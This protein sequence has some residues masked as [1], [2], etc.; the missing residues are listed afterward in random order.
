M[1]R[2]KHHGDLEALEGLV[3]RL[4]SVV[5]S[6]VYSMVRS[7]EDAEEAAQDTF[8][9]LYRARDLY[10][11]GRPLEP[12]ILRIAGNTARD[13]LRRRK[14]SNLPTA[15]TEEVSF[16][17]NLVVDPRDPEHA[18]A[19]T[20]GAIRFEVEKL[21]ERLREPLELKYIGGRTNRQIADALGISVSNVKVRIARA[22]DVLQ[23]RLEKLLEA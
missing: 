4:K 16:L 11:D 10:E 3:D 1:L 18:R 5:Y 20:Q 9:K 19:A 22:K 23:S 2:V 8:L 13:L 14:T 21:S 15:S 12:W 7:R 6:L 17:E